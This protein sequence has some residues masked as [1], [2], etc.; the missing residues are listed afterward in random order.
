MQ[1]IQTKD[2]SAVVRLLKHAEDSDERFRWFGPILEAFTRFQTEDSFSFLKHWSEARPCFMFRVFSY[3]TWFW[4]FCNFQYSNSFSRKNLK[5]GSESSDP[6]FFSHRRF[7][8]VNFRSEWRPQD[9]D[10]SLLSWIFK[11]VTCHK[12]FLN[13]RE[14]SEMD[15]RFGN[16]K[17]GL[18]MTVPSFT[19][20]VWQFFRRAVSRGFT[21]VSRL[22]LHYGTPKLVLTCFYWVLTEVIF[23]C[24]D[25]STV[26]CPTC[27]HHARAFEYVRNSRGL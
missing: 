20:N 3:E 16:D 14:D 25:L 9:S 8:T 12:K 18:R 19:V 1:K 24:P 7:M 6:P 23:L 4:I 5:I 15:W 22:R 26:L 2:C 17:F 10:E 21:F 11:M 13:L 27:R